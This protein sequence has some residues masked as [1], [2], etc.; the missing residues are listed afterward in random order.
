MIFSTKHSERRQLEDAEANGGG[1]REIRFDDSA[2][3]NA[4]MDRK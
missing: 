1:G 3:A 2:Q 4:V